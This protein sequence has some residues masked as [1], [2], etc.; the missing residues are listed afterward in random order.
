MVRSSSSSRP[1]PKA[2]VPY[3][4]SPA[5]ILRHVP[6]PTFERPTLGQSMKDGFGLGVGSGLGHAL[7][8]RMF[9]LGAP[10]TTPSP[11]APPK[12]P[13]EFERRSFELCL[14]SNNDTC[15]NKQFALTECLRLSKK[16]RE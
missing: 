12:E 10:T 13:C 9:G 16:D 4:S 7:V 6:S 1:T 2:V 14:T 15:H 5:P 8:N 3:R 11:Q